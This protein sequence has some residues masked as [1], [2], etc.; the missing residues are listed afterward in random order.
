M[1][2]IQTYTPTTLSPFIKSFWCLEVSK[3]LEQPY[4]EEILPDG[5]HEIIFHLTTPPSRKKTGSDD[6]HKDPSVFFAGQNR[7]SYLQELAPGSVI[8]AIRFHPHTQALFYDF[9]AS[10]STDHPISFSDVVANDLITGCIDSN[11]A[12]TFANMEKEFLKKASSLKNF[13]DTFQYVD[14]AVRRIILDKGNIKMETLEKITGVS[15]RHLE[16]SFQ[17]FV[18]ISPKQ[19]SNII[20]YGHFVNYRKAYPEKTLTE[21]AYEAN[22]FDQSHLIYLSHMI[23]GQSPKAY[24]NKLNYINNFFLEP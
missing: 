2:S 5:H 12:T 4:I 13:G 19:F 8:Y 22:F 24:F 15:A 21:C 16:K 3:D 18:G 17:K 7:K 14:A 10:L 6:W 11:P 9:P 20:R 23:T 1:L